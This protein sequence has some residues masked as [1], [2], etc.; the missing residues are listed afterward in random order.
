MLQLIVSHNIL[1]IPHATKT[2]SSLLQTAHETSII[3]ICL[4]I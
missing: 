4:E 1:S 3:V 2:L